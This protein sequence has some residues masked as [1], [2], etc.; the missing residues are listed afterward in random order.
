M[1]FDL[2]A[3]IKNTIKLTLKKF[4]VSNMNIKPIK[5]VED[6]ENALLEVD[7]LLEAKINSPEGDKLEV[8]TILIEAYEE[9]N[10]PIDSPDPVEAIAYTMD[11]RGLSR[12][13]LENCIGSRARVSEI[14]NHKRKLTLPM[15]QKLCTQ[16]KIPAAALIWT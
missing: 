3:C 2:L 8:I 7:R 13:D 16:F 1:L 12:K 11:C 14:L 5:T 4:K 10:F 15:I 6:Y 9:Q